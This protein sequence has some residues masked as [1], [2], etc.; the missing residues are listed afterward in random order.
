MTTETIPVTFVFTDWIAQFPE[1]T[2]VAPAAALG[3]FNRASFLCGNEATNPVAG[4]AGMLTT[5]LYLL[6]A[7]IAWL[8][9]P[10]DGSGNPASAGAAPSPIVGRINSA[11]EGSVS[12]GA[13]Y[14]DST[15]GSPSQ[16]WYM[17]S[18]YGAEYWA[19]T[20]STRTAQYVA[21]PTFLVF[22]PFGGRRLY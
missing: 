22:P 12:L 18:R 7:H 3:Y 1:F 16:P 6:T 11:S 5:L 13:D 20:A 10:R 4:Q 21:Q 9:A 19:M 2:N 14:G 15:A 17:Q 8:N